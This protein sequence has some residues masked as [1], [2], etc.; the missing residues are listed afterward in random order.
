M[1]LYNDTL[2]RMWP[3]HLGP[4]K[5]CIWQ[6][7]LY[8][9]RAKYDWLHYF[10]GEWDGRAPVNRFNHTSGVTVVT[11]TDLPKSVRNRCVIEDLVAFL[12]FWILLLV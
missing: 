10:C 5:G 6:S 1:G 4:L 9:Y 2:C 11:P 12:C 7:R 8:F 3:F